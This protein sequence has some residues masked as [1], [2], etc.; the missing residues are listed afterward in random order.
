MKYPKFLKK[1]DLVGITA[2]S[3]GT[4]DKI[5]EVKVALNHL[6]EYFH[7]IITPDVYG[8]EIVSADKETRIKEINEL[9]DEDI[10]LLLNIRGGDF[11]YETLGGIDYSKIVKK[12][13]WIMGYSDITNFLYILTTK[14][15]L[16]TIYGFNAKSFDDLVLNKYQLNNLEILQGNIIKQESF[17]N[18]TI[19][20]NGN[21]KDKGILIGGCLDTLRYL[22]G[23]EYDKT[24]SFI[25]KYKDYKIVWYFDIFS[26]D[27]VDFY[28]TV[29][30]LNKLGWFKYSD[31]FLLGRVLF[32]KEECNLSYLEAMKRVFNDKNIVF[33]ADI[34][35]VRP[36]FT[37]INGSLANI[38][39]KDD[40]LM[41][42][43][44]FLDENNG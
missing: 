33:N 36:S 17:D 4:G 32:P 38:E 13:L 1:N 31:T 11:L 6:K 20:I 12:N 22:I 42:K 40:K 44:E 14:Y 5:L 16:A 25:E 30:E 7:L 29:L 8:E 41:L 21:F 26:M 18:S 19:S 39:Y 15:D 27:S 2:L 9:L 3:S 35:H 28:L 37:L 10:K 34:G 24:N 23:T 43:M